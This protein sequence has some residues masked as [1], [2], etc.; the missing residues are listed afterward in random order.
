MKTK[1]YRATQ[2]TAASILLAGLKN[3]RNRARAKSGRIRVV[4]VVRRKYTQ[5]AHYKR[6]V[7]GGGRVA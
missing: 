7:G 2:F 3:A 1:I 5:S 6:A 4:Q